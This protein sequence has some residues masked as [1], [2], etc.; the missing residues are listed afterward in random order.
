MTTTLVLGGARSGK[1]RFAQAQAE[2][3]FA[4]LTLIATAQ[5]FDDEMAQRIARHRADRDARWRV[6]E[7]PYDLA[8][9]LRAAC[10]PE[11]AVVVDCL[12]LWLSNLMHAGRD[13]AA[14]G[15]ALLAALASAQ[16]AVFLVSNE[17]GL[18]LVPDNP[19]G[20]AF[21]DAQGWLNQS[22]AQISAR[23]VFVAA[24]L[25]LTLKDETAP[26]FPAPGAPFE[27]R[28]SGQ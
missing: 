24:G 5:A 20:R 27:A 17:V 14:A 4:P 12:T 8:A 11:R 21:R 13:L 9:A 25:P 18:G 6:I 16:G 10:A 7:E 15:D 1:S 3:L 22:V 26:A 28:S 19:L 2:S 23:V